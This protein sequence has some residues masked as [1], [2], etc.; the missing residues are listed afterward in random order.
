MFPLK[1]V[2]L[3]LVSLFAV[4]EQKDKEELKVYIEPLVA[5]IFYPRCCCLWAK[6]GMRL[7]LGQK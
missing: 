1:G 7:I 6:I 5:I 2:A 3:V 4:G